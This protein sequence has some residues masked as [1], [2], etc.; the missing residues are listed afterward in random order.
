MILVWQ[1]K[2][3]TSSLATQ[4]RQ[5]TERQAYVIIVGLSGTDVVKWLWSARPRLRPGKGRRGVRLCSRPVSR[6]G[7]GCGAAAPFRRGAGCASRGR[8]AQGMGYRCWELP[9]QRIGAGARPDEAGGAIYWEGLV[10]WQAQ[11]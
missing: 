11:P 7:G 4:P 10:W 8:R 3:S 2:Y 9:L 1:R 5:L 6:R